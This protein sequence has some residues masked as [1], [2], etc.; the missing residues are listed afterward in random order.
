MIEKI[1][2]GRSNGF[3]SKLVWLTQC[4]FCHPQLCT[5]SF[6]T[7]NHA[8]KKPETENTW[9]LMSMHMYEHAMYNIY[10]AIIFFTGQ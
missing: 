1:L 4:F 10:T 5:P 7:S 9:T 3:F 8:L 2:D 6:S